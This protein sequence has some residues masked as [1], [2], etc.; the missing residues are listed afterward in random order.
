[1]DDTPQRVICLSVSA[2]AGH[3]QAAQAVL[4]GLKLARPELP[5]E[6]IDVMGKVPGWFRAFYTGGY[7]VVVTHL[8]SWYGFGYRLFDRPHTPQRGLSE[9]VRMCYERFEMR[10]LRSYLLSQRPAVVLCTHFLP[11]PMVGRMIGR[12]VQG[13]RLMGVVTD[14]EAHRWWYGENVERYFVPNDQVKS[15]MGRWNI[16]PQRITVSGIPVHPKWTAPL[17][18]ARIYADWQLPADRPI[19]MLSG[20]TFFT[21]GPTVQIARGILDRTNACVVVLAGRNKQLQADLASFPEAW[22]G[23]GDAASAASSSA[24]GASCPLPRLKIVPFTDKVHELAEVSTVMVTKAGGLTTSECIAKGV[25]MILTKSVPGQEE[26]NARM[27]E[28]EGA[29]IRAE[30][31]DAIIAAVTELLADPAKVASLRANARRLYHPG[32][33]IIVDEVLRTM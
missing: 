9:R 33:Q 1:M 10:H 7:N 18:R 24:T 16:D 28:A 6:F 25:A 20:G 8:P 17:D 13:L 19:V 22:G 3:N 14:N 15:S 26:A 27:L 4:A 30:E 29:A 5:T 12:G 2:G 11:I 21:V 32:T 23:S 31:V